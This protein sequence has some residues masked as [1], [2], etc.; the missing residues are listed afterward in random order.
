MKDPVQ[1]DPFGEYAATRLWADQ[2]RD[3]SGNPAST[4]LKVCAVLAKHGVKCFK[5]ALAL[6]LAAL[7][8]KPLTSAQ[9]SG[10]TP[11]SS[12]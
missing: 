4:E 9:P 5:R 10:H 11:V 12:G 3:R 2:L 8:D 1:D 6:D 7:I